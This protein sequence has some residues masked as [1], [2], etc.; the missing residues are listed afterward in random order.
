MPSAQKRGRIP[1]SF[2]AKQG[3]FR[4]SP[5]RLALMMGILAFG[6]ATFYIG[7]SW[8]SQKIWGVPSQVNEFLDKKDITTL[9]EKGF[10]I[11]TGSNPPDI[12]GKYYIAPWTVHFDS[13][14]VFPVGT[15]IDKTYYRFFNQKRDG[16]VDVEYYTENAGETGSGIGSFISGEGNCFTIFT[17]QKGVIEGCNHKAPFVVSGCL[18]EKG[19][20]N[21]TLSNIMKWQEDTQTCKE[22]AM[23]VG[24]VRIIIEDDKL[25]EKVV[26]EK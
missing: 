3:V 9:G 18:T 24:N 6:V 17:E 11:Y 12:T 21:W 13:G 15:E 7:Y 22:V 23:P 10:P 25:A 1:S 4:L 8:Y 26:D 19:I 5:L 14:N 2:R 16:K 20:A